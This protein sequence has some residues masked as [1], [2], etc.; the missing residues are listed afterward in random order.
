MIHKRSH[1]STKGSRLALMRWPFF[2]S[3]GINVLCLAE[4][5]ESAEILSPDGENFRSH[6]WHGLCKKI[7]FFFDIRKKSVLLHPK[8]LFR[9]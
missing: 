6:R 5:A 7:H 4:I 3:R 2:V 1:P 9:K 8:W